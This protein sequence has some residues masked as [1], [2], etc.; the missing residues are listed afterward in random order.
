MEKRPNRNMY[1]QR[2]KAYE[3][4]KS[5]AGVVRSKLPSPEKQR[6]T[7]WCAHTGLNADQT[8]QEGSLRMIAYD[9]VL[10]FDLSTERTDGLVTTSGPEA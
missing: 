1:E 5:Y 10:T 6:W 4:P 3:D 8:S 7:Y 9:N 2:P